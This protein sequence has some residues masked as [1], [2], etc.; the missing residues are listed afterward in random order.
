MNKQQDRA[1]QADGHI[2][3]VMYA[4]N[5]GKWLFPHTF[6]PVSSNI[7]MSNCSHMSDSSDELEEEREEENPSGWGDALCT[8]TLKQM[9]EVA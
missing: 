6:F 3:K 7:L 8:N 1:S 9:L 2:A 5:A 4:N